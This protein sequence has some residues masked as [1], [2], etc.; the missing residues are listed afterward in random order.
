M[1]LKIVSRAAFMTVAMLASASILAGGNHEHAASH[2]GIYVKNKTLDIEV[3]A[4]TDV[5]QVYL[6][7]PGK[8]VPLMG[9]KAKVTLL[10]GTEKSEV[11]LV[12][13]GDKL[14]AKGTFKVA[15]G[16]KGVVLVTQAGKP[17]TTARFTVK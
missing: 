2:G 5:I 10:N 17:G 7:D 13:A 15:K 6:G 4:K 3:V 12:P 14:E 8:P 1:Y 9:V 11:E 16:T